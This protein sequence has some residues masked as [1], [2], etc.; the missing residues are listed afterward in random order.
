MKILLINP[1]FGK[2]NDYCDTSLP[3]LGL[4]YLAGTIKKKYPDI[5]MK[6]VEGDISLSDHLNIVQD[7]NPD[8]YGIS[9]ATF[10]ASYAYKTINDVRNIF[11]DIIIIAGGPHPTRV[12][13]QK[14]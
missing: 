4:L 9:F 12:S 13:L 10:T 14:G 2:M 6:Y 11:P 8:V 3:N 1:A 5:S 7:F